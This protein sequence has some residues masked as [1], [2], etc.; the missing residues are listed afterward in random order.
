M[1][2]EVLLDS[3]VVGLVISSEFSRKQGITKKLVLAVSDLDKKM[4]IEV[5]VSDYAIGGVLSIECEDRR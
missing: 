4:R 1:M 2:V 5:D 3:G